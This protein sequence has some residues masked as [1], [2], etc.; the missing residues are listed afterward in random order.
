MIDGLY[1]DMWL[2]SDQH[3]IATE[4][5][6]TWERGRLVPQPR[7][8]DLHRPMGS[9][10]AEAE[11]DENQ[12]AR[13]EFLM[14]KLSQSERQCITAIVLHDEHPNRYGFHQT[15]QGLDKLWSCLNKL[16]PF[17]N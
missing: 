1:Q 13:H 3:I 6:D 14:G 17:F 5:R 4:L 15:G 11:V 12:R 7:S 10:S 16:T 9:E 2:S 8:R